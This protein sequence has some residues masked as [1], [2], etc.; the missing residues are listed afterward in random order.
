M[1]IAG[2]S[3]SARGRVRSSRTRPPWRQLGLEIFI[4]DP[5]VPMDTNHLERNLR[6][7]PISRTTDWI[8]LRSYPRWVQFI[9]AVYALAFAIGT[10][11]H[12]NAILHGSWVPHHPFLNAYW[13]SLTLLDPLVVFLLFRSPRAGLLLALAVMLTDV[14]INSLATYLYLE[15]DGKRYAV[16]YFVQLQTAFLGFVLGSTPF[17]WTRFDYKHVA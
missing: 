5:D 2:V 14:G 7:I 3:A 4:T 8:R 16:D 11:T 12:L 13:A 6:A 9:L 10:S 15:T 1:A 17:L